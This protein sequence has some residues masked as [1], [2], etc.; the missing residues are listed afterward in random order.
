MLT[1]VLKNL[2][3]TFAESIEKHAFKQS[4]YRVEELVKIFIHATKMETGFWEM[5]SAPE[6]SKDFKRKAETRNTHHSHIRW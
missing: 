1:I 4:P 3:M 2:R 6:P 5:A